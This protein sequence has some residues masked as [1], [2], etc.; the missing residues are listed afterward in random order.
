MDIVLY[1]ILGIIVGGALAWFFV[2]RTKTAAPAQDTGAMMMLQGQMAE[3]A[4][5][6]D[7]K[8]TES[9]RDMTEA[10]RTQ[11][12][13][14]QKLLREINEQMNK[15]LVEVAREQTKTNESTTRFMAIAEQLANLEKVLKHQKQRG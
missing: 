8:L 9:R 1:I 11:F 3:L 13:E 10:V 12:S 2:N 7:S 14:S 15:S 5:Q 4:K 6:L